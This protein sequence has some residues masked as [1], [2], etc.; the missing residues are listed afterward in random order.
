MSVC[1][2]STF[3]RHGTIASLKLWIEL[4]H[5]VIHAGSPRLGCRN[6]HAV[7]LPGHQCPADVALPALDL[8][9]LCTWSSICVLATAGTALANGRPSFRIRTLRLAQCWPPALMST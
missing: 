1:A 6:G 2:A 7:H 8:S 9:L 5:H 4:R 3:V